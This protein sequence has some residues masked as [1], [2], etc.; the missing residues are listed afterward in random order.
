M[1]METKTLEWF[2]ENS[3]FKEFSPF[4]LDGFITVLEVE[5]LTK[6]ARQ[7]ISRQLDGIGDYVEL[8]TPKWSE[9]VKGR[10]LKI[11]ARIIAD[12]F[13]LKSGLDEHEK[14][15]L[16]EIVNDVD[17][18]R[19]ITKH[20]INLDSAIRKLIF[21]LLLIGIGRGKSKQKSRFSLA[22]LD[23]LFVLLFFDTSFKKKKSKEESCQGKDF[24][25][26]LIQNTLTTLGEEDF[27]RY[28]SSII[29][30]IQKDDK[31]HTFDALFNKIMMQEF[32]ITTNMPTWGLILDLLLNIKNTNLR[33]PKEEKRAIKEELSKIVQETI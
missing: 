20:N 7:T 22:N 21:T 15:L 2:F 13:A 28:K 11:N 16:C 17:I 10:P 25:I 27:D 14:D 9:K 5:K 33:M 6:I 24:T 23:R 29:G 32:Y 30:Y 26:S 8:P 3:A 4:F 1:S 31:C 12:Y 18:N 19:I